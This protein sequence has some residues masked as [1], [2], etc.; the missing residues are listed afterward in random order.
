MS[1]NDFLATTLDPASHVPVYRQIA[2]HLRAVIASG[3][4][5]DGDQLPSEAQLMD[6]YGVVRMTVRSGIKVL[7]DEAL[8]TSEHG[9]GVCARGRPPVRWLAS[10]WTFTAGLEHAPLIPRLIGPLPPLHRAY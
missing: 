7:Q 3:R 4:V 5:H 10:A 9:K 8:M 2:E 6:H 1:H